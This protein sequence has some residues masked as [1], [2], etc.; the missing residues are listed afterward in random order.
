MAKQKRI[1]IVGTF[2]VANFGDLL[3]PVVAELELSRRLD[4]I[5][6]TR[7]SY[8]ALSSGAWPFE[9]KAIGQLERDVDALDLLLVGGGDLIRFD[10]EIASGYQPSE[11]SIHHPTGFWLLPTLLAAEH[12][13]P[14]VWNA[15][16]VQAPPEWA[17]HLLSIAVASATLVTVRD[18][19]SQEILSAATDAAEAGL[20]PDTAF[21]VRAALDTAGAERFLERAGADGPY[22]VFQPSPDLLP[23]RQ[24]LE[25]GLAAIEETHRGLLVLPISPVHGDARDLLHFPTKVLG[26]HEW[27]SPRV[28]AAVISGAD[29][30]VGVSLHLSIVALA[31]GV[32]VFRPPP[33][34]PS[35]Y[36]SLERFDRCHYWDSGAGLSALIR[37]Q[38]R[39]RDDPGPLVAEQ[40][41]RLAAHWDRVAE[42]AEEGT[43]SRRP[44]G[45]LITYATEI[46]EDSAVAISARD[47]ELVIRQA[48]IDES[49]A[50]LTT[51]GKTMEQV[52]AELSASATTRRELEHA[53]HRERLEATALGHH[54]DALYATKTFRYSRFLRRLYRVLIDRSSH[55]S[56]EPM[57]EAETLQ[58]DDRGRFTRFRACIRL[59]PP[60]T[61]EQIMQ[62]KIELI[63]G[64]GKAT[65]IR[66]F[67]GVW[68]VNGLY[69][70]E[71]ARALGCQ[72]A[73]MVDFSATPELEDRL[74]ALRKELSLEVRMT[75]G[76]FREAELIEK[77]Q[78]VDVSILYEVLLHQDNAVEVVKNVASKTTRCLCVA[79]PVL[80]ESFFSLPNGAVNLQFYPEELKD[81]LR[82][83]GWWEAEPRTDRFDTRY[84]MWGQTP[85]YLKSVLQG[86]GWQP[87]YEAL[88]EASEHWDYVLM[89]FVPSSPHP[90]SEVASG[91]L[92]CVSG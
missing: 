9:V 3:F 20:V 42:L 83:P 2:D 57:A 61:Y 76:D 28:L 91:E 27:P 81:E 87:A 11:P 7:Y 67:G 33:R 66:D 58:L 14:V 72:R 23:L 12:D 1:G 92:E 51:L 71:G 6:M 37:T 10:K 19:V 32:P 80:K 41:A 84:W 59:Q 60:Q 24:E 5:S 26:H 79:Q 38:S 82:F 64:I 45:R 54:L 55:H 56:S 34:P 90:M 78:S 46:A 22:V 50:G 31:T 52:R 18:Q 68:G 47:T 29:A 48:R 69:L 62:R 16:G 36:S 17:R 39:P 13:V 35:K 44:G 70:I 85:S 43:Q 53:L 25:E 30:V 8:S 15:V 73:E 75:L 40:L 77:L 88:Y 21:G 86:Y 65:S 49:E 89:R 4:S 74:D 63:A